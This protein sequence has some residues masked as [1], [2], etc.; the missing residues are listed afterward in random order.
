[1]ETLLPITYLN[2]FVFCPHSIYLHQV[3]DNAEIEVYSAAPQQKGREAWRCI[4][5]GRAI[6]PF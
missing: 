5:Y 6:K 2:D 3:F 4:C 1:M